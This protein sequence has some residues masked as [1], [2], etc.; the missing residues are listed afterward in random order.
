LISFPVGGGEKANNK[1]G[2]EKRYRYQRRGGGGKNQL[3]LVSPAAFRLLKGEKKERR[4]ANR[5]TVRVGA[6]KGR[7]EKNNKSQPRKK[8]KRKKG[9]VPLPFKGNVKR[10]IV[11]FLCN[12]CQNC[13]IRAQ[14]EDKKFQWKK[15]KGATRL[16]TGEKK[17]GRYNR[18]VRTRGGE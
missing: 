17:R 14:K 9:A 3:P 6:W 4:D 2:G 11:H 5:K 1:K 18:Q 13:L 16:V 8:R 7:T 12:S 15:K 10:G